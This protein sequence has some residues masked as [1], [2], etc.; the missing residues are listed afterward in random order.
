MSYTYK[1]VLSKLQ[2]LLENYNIFLSESYYAD[3]TP[4]LANDMRKGLELCESA[5]MFHLF[6]SS[7]GL[8][9]FAIRATNALTY[10][11]TIWSSDKTIYTLDD[12]NCLAMLSAQ[13]TP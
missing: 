5:T 6:T 13:H 7:E 11:A 10:S 1:D 2:S 9:K 3:I 12:F 4:D 8:A